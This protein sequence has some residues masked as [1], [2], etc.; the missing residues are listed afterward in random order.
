MS[1]FA[2][3]IIES[4]S[5]YTAHD[6]YWINLPSFFGDDH[7]EVSK[8][9]SDSLQT[10]FQ[11]HGPDA[12][13]DFT[14]CEG[15]TMKY[16]TA[17]KALIYAIKKLNKSNLPEELRE[18]SH[19]DFID[20]GFSLETD[21]R[22]N[23]PVTGELLHCIP[24]SKSMTLEELGYLID[25]DKMSKDDW[26]W[27]DFVVNSFGDDDSEINAMLNRIARKFR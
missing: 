17:Y 1:T 22:D 20:G 24:V 11:K 15:R 13:D 25:Q 14:S 26:V 7:E 12:V 8:A 2:Q 6:P 18:I 23:D 19:H 10:F 21:Y 16:E 9:M 3:R 27:C 5:D 4:H